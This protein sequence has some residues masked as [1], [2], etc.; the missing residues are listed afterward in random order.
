MI[1]FY[2]YT[3]ILTYLSVI[4]G[5]SGIMVCLNGVGHPFY[6]TFFLLFSGLCDTFDGRV[7]RSKS[8]RTDMQKSFGVQ[9]DSLADL[10]SFGIL[11]PCIGLGMVRTSDRLTSIPN[12]RVDHPGE[13]RIIYPVFLILIIMVYVLAAL[14]RLAYFNVLEEEKKKIGSQVQSGYIGLPVT[15]AA[16]IFPTVML[17]QFLTKADLTLLYFGVMLFTSVFFVS[18]IRIPKPDLKVAIL[19][20]GI[21]AAEFFA[22]IVVKY[23]LHI[24]NLTIQF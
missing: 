16:L 24:Q 5:V 21:G 15:S 9:I 17:F 1:G 19:L 7:A 10:I 12:L 11:P 18:R 6:G 22:L 2:D 20:I 4:S 8:G 13:K 23:Y 14:I 3:V